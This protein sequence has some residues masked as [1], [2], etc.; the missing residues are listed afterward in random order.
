MIMDGP[1]RIGPYE[2]HAIETGSFALDGGAMFGIVPKPVWEKTNP[3]D[4]L[5][6]I[7][8]R[9]RCLLLIDRAAKRVLLVD[10]GIGTKWAEKFMQMYRIDHSQWALDRELARVGLTPDDVTDVIATHLHFDHMGGTTR[11]VNG[12]LVP[13]FPKARVW[14]QEQ[15]W[16]LAYHPNEKDRASYL[17]E[18]FDLY[19]GNPKLELLQ[20][21]Y[22]RSDE[23]APG[24][25]VRVSNG[26]TPGLQLVEVADSGSALI[27]CADAVPTATHVRTP[28]VMGYDCFPLT[29]MEEKKKLLGEAEERGAILF[30][31]HCPRMQ[32]ATVF[33]DGKDFSIKQ[34]YQFR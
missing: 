15:N 34:A 3:A 29:M 7:E 22:G 32:A 19:R 21:E 14:V 6:R 33:H 20:T 5:N 9:L 1:G 10:N 4:A 11:R 17:Q 28:W 16:N 25:R 18:N 12:E 13:T 30:F 27:Y 26:H 2:I 23:I 31:E 8:M 24:I